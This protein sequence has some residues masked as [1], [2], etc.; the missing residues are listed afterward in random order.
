MSALKTPALAVGEAPR[1][2][3]RRGACPSL[4]A[5][6]ATG[7]GLLV[8]LRPQAPGLSPAEWMTMA[9][10]ARRTGNGLLEVTARGN[11]Q[12]RGLTAESAAPLAEGLQAAGIETRTGTAI[13]VPPLSGLDP[14]E[15]ADAT[16]LAEAIRQGIAGHVPPLALAPK[17][18]ITVNGGGC[19]NLSTASA[20][21]RLDAVKAE[22]GVLWR[23]ALAGDAG[24][25][26]PVALL[27]EEA[28]A[29]RVMDL[30]CA[31][32]QRGGHARGRDIAPDIEGSGDGAGPEAGFPAPVRP[33]GVIRSGALLVLA[34][35]LAYGR[36]HADELEA[37]MAGLQ[38]LGATEIRLAPDHALL[39][40]GLTEETVE[41]AAALA[42]AQGLITSPSDPAHFI[43]AC[44]GTG[45]CAA[46]RIN[47]RQLAERLI[48]AA[49]AAEPGVLDGSCRVHVSGC[50][51]GCA[52]PQAAALTVTG[53]EQGAAI[54]LGERADSRPDLQ[55]SPQRL[56]TVLPR[57]QRG[58]ELNRQPGQTAQH[59]LGASGAA[60]L[61]M[62][63]AER[64]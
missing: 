31:L 22:G 54:V 24:S 43:S 7:D 41:A 40:L 15:T 46:A 3:V 49:S 62:A 44:P 17:L 28:A 51:K 18:A 21:I 16:E 47:T 48:S 29:A 12:I 5:P 52:H 39:V 38:R 63:G 19:F 59:V 55:L 36:I 10:L 11:L 42:G 35:R 8:R 32:S 60:I 64:A 20:D 13:E 23:L 6:M 26:K 61:A 4:A 45:F 1:V 56:E 57:L 34:L 37:L 58:I 25:A 33:A 14:S 27:P 50:S 30:L 2:P 53:T 9:G